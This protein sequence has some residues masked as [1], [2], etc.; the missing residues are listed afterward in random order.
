MQPGAALIRQGLQS[1]VHAIFVSQATLQHVAL[2][3]AHGSDEEFQIIQAPKNLHRAFGGHLFHAFVKGFA[4]AHVGGVNPGKDFGLKLGKRLVVESIA[5]RDGVA[6]GKLTRV[7]DA[8]DVSGIRHV[9]GVAVPGDETMGPRQTNFMA[10]SMM[11]DRHVAFESSGTHSQEGGAVSM[12]GI[13][14]RLDFE[15]VGAE[16]RCDGVDDDFA[17]IRSVSRSRQGRGCHVHKGVEEIFNPEVRQRGRKKDGR[18]V[19][20]EKGLVRIG[21][22]GHFQEF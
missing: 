13:H 1:R 15:H 4:F 2:Q 18:H 8:D 10:Q 11:R 21:I 12:S 22:A 17:P 19:T 14:V 7:D 16:R 5:E 9:Y 3:A 6:D 20:G